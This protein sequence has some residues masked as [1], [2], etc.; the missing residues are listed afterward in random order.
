MMSY[1]ILHKQPG[2]TNFFT[3]CG[4]FL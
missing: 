1:V 2:I 4:F 3:T